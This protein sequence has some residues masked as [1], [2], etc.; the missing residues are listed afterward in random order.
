MTPCGPRSSV[1]PCWMQRKE[2]CRAPSGQTPLASLLKAT[3]TVHRSHPFSCAC[4]LPECAQAGDTAQTQPPEWET[5]W[6]RAVN[7]C[8]A[9]VSLDRHRTAQQHGSV[10][11]AH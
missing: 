1:L 10:Q 2:P 8:S 7:S 4:V 9:A 5:T 6:F 3:I 11:L